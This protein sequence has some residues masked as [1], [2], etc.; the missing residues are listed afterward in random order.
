MG[1][2]KGYVTNDL[3]GGSKHVTGVALIIHYRTGP[4]KNIELLNTE[5]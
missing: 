1:I 5:S 2:N 3:A 4:R